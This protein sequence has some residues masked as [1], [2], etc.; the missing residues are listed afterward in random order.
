MYIIH[1]SINRVYLYIMFNGTCMD[2]ERI[3]NLR[4]ASRPVRHCSGE[5]GSL[6]GRVTGGDSQHS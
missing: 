6:R 2:R 3:N 1:L 4:S 5:R